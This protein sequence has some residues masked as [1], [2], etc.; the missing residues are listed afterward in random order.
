MSIYVGPNIVNLNNGLV[1]HVDAANI[2]S[3]NTV[4]STSTWRDISGNG[5]VATLTN[6][7]VY[8][9]AN[10]G[11]FQ[12]NGVNQYASTSY[13]QPAYQTTSSFTWNVW[14]NSLNTSGTG[15]PLTI[16]NRNYSVSPFYDFTKIDNNLNFEFYHTGTIGIF[17]PG[18]VSSGTWY[19][20]SIVKNTSSFAYYVN[21]VQVNS[22]NLVTSVGTNPQAFW[23][24]GSNDSGEYGNANISVVSIYSRALSASEVDQNFQALRDRY[25]I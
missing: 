14:I 4:T 6:S 7:P 18:A 3:Y 10:G 19:N 17:G 5:Y 21:G 9:P 22:M 12:F 23:I 16:G 2:N 1:F 25:G 24:G 13:T 11:Y 8:N 15:Y 20:I